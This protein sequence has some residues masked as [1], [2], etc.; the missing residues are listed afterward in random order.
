MSSQPATLNAWLQVRRYAVP[1]WMI[2]EATRCQLAGDWRGACAAANIDV[3]FDLAA[4][5]REHGRAVAG[6]VEDDLHHLAP[7]LLRWHVGRRV[8]QSTAPAREP[9]LL[10]SYRGGQLQVVPRYR[11][12]PGPLLVLRF[13]GPADPRR[14]LHANRERWDVRRT[15]D[16]LARHGGRLPFLT[17]APRGTAEEI[18]TLQDAGRWQDA[19]RLAGFDIDALDDASPV[20]HER[21]S[22]VPFDLTTLAASARE[23]GGPEAL[24]DLSDQ[25]LWI[26]GHRQRVRARSERADIPPVLPIA[27][28]ERPVDLDLV[29]LGRLTLDELHPLVAAALVAGHDTAAG[30][31]SPVDMSP[32]GVRCGTGH[33]LIGPAGVPHPPE[34]IRREQSLHA[35]GGAMPTGCFAAHLGWRDPRFPLPRVPRRRRATVQEQARHGDGPALTAWLDAG[36]DPHLRTEDGCTMLHLI[37]WL[38][39]PAPL[40]TRLVAAGLDL[41]ARNAAGATPLR[42]A[43]SSGGTVAAIRALAAAGAST[44]GWDETADRAGRYGELRFLSAT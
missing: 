19:W 33:H 32:Y 17:G 1:A 5:A 11:D 35:L 27:R 39:D 7:D 10:A 31:P 36:L 13:A 41:E 26:D 34:E 24:V 28:V 15:G 29:R 2:D 8:P 22:A 30:P 12:T 20:L 14:G 37:A 43:I 18:I 38:P 4:I 3:D 40:V 42:F 21:I 16:L 23:L 9:T 6:A 25:F 44:A